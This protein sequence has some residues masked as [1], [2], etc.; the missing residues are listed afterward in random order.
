MTIKSTIKSLTKLIYSVT[1]C[2]GMYVYRCSKNLMDHVPAM[3]VLNQTFFCK[4][5]YS[6]T[7]DNEFIISCRHEIYGELKS[8]G[9]TSICSAAHRGASE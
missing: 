3:K 1:D 7:Y 2:N 6:G 8:L 4:S 9:A 5:V